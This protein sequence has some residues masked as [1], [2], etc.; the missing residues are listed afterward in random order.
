MATAVW[1]SVRSADDLRRRRKSVAEGD[2]SGL[3]NHGSAVREESPVRSVGSTY[4]RCMV[5]VGEKGGSQGLIRRIIGAGS[6]SAVRWCFLVFSVP[7]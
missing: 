6:F 5:G 4:N 1:A 3:V 2:G 7:T